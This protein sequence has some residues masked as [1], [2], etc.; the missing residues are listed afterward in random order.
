MQKKVQKRNKKYEEISKSLRVEKQVLIHDMANLPSFT[1]QTVSQ[2]RLLK[3]IGHCS[4]FN[5]QITDNYFDAKSFLS[6]HKY[7]E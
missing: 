5:G 2:K 1:R 4:R 7:R 6:S 3:I